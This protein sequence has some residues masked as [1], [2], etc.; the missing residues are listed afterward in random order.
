MPEDNLTAA[1]ARSALEAQIFADL[2]AMTA[3]SEHIGRAF[4]TLHSLHPT[5]FRALLHIMVADTEGTPLSAGRLGS[6]LGLSS[7]AMT[8]LAERLS[9]SGHIRREGDPSDRRKSLLRYNEPG[10]AVAREFFGPLGERTSAALAG[11]DDDDLRAAH[12]VFAAL[13]AAMREHAAELA[14]PPAP[15]D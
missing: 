13:T 7:A 12:R 10:M 11:I 2:R 8:Y 1:G 9:A 5:D 4:S 14:A 3:A 6:M 15:Q